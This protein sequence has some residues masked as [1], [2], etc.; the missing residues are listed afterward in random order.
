LGHAS[1]RRHQSNAWMNPNVRHAEA[2]IEYTTVGHIILSAI[3]S[4]P[5]YGAPK[6]GQPDHPMLPLS[7]HTRRSKLQRQGFAPRVAMFGKNA[8]VPRG[9]ITAGAST[10]SMTAPVQKSRGIAS[11]CRKVDSG[12]APWGTPPFCAFPAVTMRLLRYRLLEHAIDL[13]VD[14]LDRL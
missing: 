11:L 7:L 5:N 4:A 14:L 6:I 13:L 9:I 10:G 8:D 3:R 1:F 2:V 12:G